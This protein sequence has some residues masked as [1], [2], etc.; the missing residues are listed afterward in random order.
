MNDDELAR[1]ASDL[2]NIVEELED[3]A[4]REA[5]TAR[6]EFYEKVERIYNIAHTLKALSAGV[7]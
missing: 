6:D 5:V 7:K 2:E 3:W 1:V 4:S